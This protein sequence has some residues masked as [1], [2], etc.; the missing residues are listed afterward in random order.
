MTS[1][2]GIPL[3]INP[4]VCENL[5]SDIFVPAWSVDV[6]VDEP[7]ANMRAIVIDDLP[8]LHLDIKYISRG[9]CVV[10]AA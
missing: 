5:L 1:L 8:L 4:T 7:S 3:Y 9:S 6:V 10:G 2:F